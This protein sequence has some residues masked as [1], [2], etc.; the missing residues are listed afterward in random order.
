M[1][2]ENI[3]D[4]LKTIIFLAKQNKDLTNKDNG[5]IKR[6]KIG[7]KCSSYR[8]VG[9]LLGTQNNFDPKD[10]KAVVENFSLSF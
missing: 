5:V 8:V 1:Y 7:V 2:L 9:R 3:L 6:S 10:R 4:K